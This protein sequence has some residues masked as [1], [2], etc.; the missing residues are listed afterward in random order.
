M[1]RSGRPTLL[2]LGA[3]GFLGL[4]VLEHARRADFPRVVGAARR[5]PALTGTEGRAIELAHAT[6]LDRLL[7]ETDPTHVIL[8]AAASRAEACRRDPAGARA[9][10]AE[11]PER[12]A[13]TC[14]VRGA[15][16]VHVSTD[17]VFGAR[18]PR[19]ARFAEDD[20]PAPLSLYGCTKAEGEARALAALP[21]ALVVRLPL[22]FGDSRGRG[23]GAS[24]ALLAEL[25]RGGTPTLFEDEWRTPLDVDEAAAALLELAR[26]EARGLLHVAG[27][28]RLSRHELGLALL[29]AH[30][31]AR[32]E[33]LVR[34][35]RRAEV[36]AGVERP[37]DVSLDG[38]RALALLVTPLHGARALGSA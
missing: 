7:D 23:L 33:S 6:Q 3:S 20:A 21:A 34:V 16:L 25:E 14:A 11:L 2:V 32:P 4:P 27:P 38:T 9:M 28:V 19:G 15:R 8:C 12:V 26:G 31:H 29:R 35:V 24:D 22:L 5:P 1:P 10:N 36:T 37:R 13:R 17:L 30:G 18:E